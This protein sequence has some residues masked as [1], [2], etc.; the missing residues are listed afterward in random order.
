MKTITKKV[1]EVDLFRGMLGEVKVTCP[2]CNHVDTVVVF[3]EISNII[4]TCFECMERYEIEIK[5]DE[6]C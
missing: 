5:E 2:Y 4:H 6:K 1:S 3:T